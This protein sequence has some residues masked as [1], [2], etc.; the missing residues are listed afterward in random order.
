[1]GVFGSGF[2][3]GG[4]GECLAGV[5]VVERAVLG[6]PL[7]LVVDDAVPVREGAALD[8]LARDADVVP[9]LINESALGESFITQPEMRTWFPSL[10]KLAHA[11]CSP[12]A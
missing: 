12:I 7:L 8:V 9:L 1:M 2:G 6:A 3:D 4:V 11:S 10:S 5:D